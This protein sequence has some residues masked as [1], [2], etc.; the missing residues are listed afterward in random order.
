MSES[1]Q[2]H[3]DRLRAQWRRELPDLETRPMAVLG[4][5]YRLSKLVRPSIEAVFAQFALDRGEFDILATLRRAGAPFRLT[6]T[7]LYTSLMIPSGSL[8]HRLGRLERAG[9][10]RR[11]PSATDG[12]SLAVQLTE[13][14]RETVEA[15]FR[16]DMACEAEFLS[17]LTPEEIQALAGLLRK[18]NWAIENRHRSTQRD[19]ASKASE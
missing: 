1:I 11:L 13:A 8:T 14:G 6:P 4:R 5:A 17:G 2:D 19:Q 18:L 16:L 3:V 12:R 10:V 9:L 15:A 7:E